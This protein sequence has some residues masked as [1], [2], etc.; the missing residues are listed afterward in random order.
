MRPARLLLCA[1]VLSGCERAAAPD[2][3]LPPAEVGAQ[4]APAATDDANTGADG[5]TVSGEPVAAQDTLIPDTAPAAV[6]PANGLLDGIASGDDT[7]AS[8]RA[9]YGAENVVE[10]ELAVGEGETMPGWVLFP[11]RPTRQLEV[12]LDET[13]E[14]PAMLVAGSDVTEWQRADGVRNGLT[15]A[16]LTAINGRPFSFMGFYWDYGGVVIDWKGGALG[17]EDTVVG[18]VTLCPPQF[19]DE[20]I[21]DGYPAGDGEYASDLAILTTFPP[22]VCEFGVVLALPPR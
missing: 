12:H 3:S 16:E 20:D 5:V 14:H 6:P 19:A 13:G 17:P 15:A 4:A 21:P 18:P 8:L 11:D 7:L 9:R 22:V 10:R 1:L 2:P